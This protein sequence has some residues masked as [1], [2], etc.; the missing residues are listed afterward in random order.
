MGNLIEQ[1]AGVVRAAEGRAGRPAAICGQLLRLALQASEMPAGALLVF[2]PITL[3]LE[4]MASR[5]GERSRSALAG[6]AAAPERAPEIFR[7][8][9]EGTP[10]VM[11]TGTPDPLLEALTAHEENCDAVLF[12]PLAAYGNPA[13]LLILAGPSEV[14]PSLVL[15]DLVANAAVL[16]CLLPRFVS[17]ESES[18]L[19]DVESVTTVSARHLGDTVVLLDDAVTLDGITI[20]GHKVLVEVPSVD[21]VHRLQGESPALVIANLAAPETFDALL[22]LR[23]A[24]IDCPV[25]GCLSMTSAGH[26]LPLGRVEVVPGP[27]DT[28]QAL[29]GIRRVAPP[30]GRVLGVGTDS[31]GLLGLR[32]TLVREGMQVMLAWDVD[33]GLRQLAAEKPEVLLIDLALEG[34][35]GYRLVG[36]AARCDPRPA[37]V[38]VPGF[39]QPA[40]SFL[41]LFITNEKLLEDTPPLQ[42]LLSA[43]VT[44]TESASTVAP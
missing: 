22:A 25:V 39:G 38:L 41:D 8:I 33:E 13:G 18:V 31:S 17:G 23:A 1:L 32:Q 10:L 35:G 30:H 20:A 5:M 19:V 9:R 16:G 43:L 44:P 6:L 12:L 34:D 21:I 15:S 40:E 36:E 11:H 7:A 37:L 29:E 24:G 14:V 26:S 2:D 4:L 28:D 42:D 3:R 27:V